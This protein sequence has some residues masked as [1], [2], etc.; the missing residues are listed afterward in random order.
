MVFI[1]GALR[2]VRL[3]RRLLKAGGM[4][5]PISARAR[6]FSTTCS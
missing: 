3:A 4:F 5:A 1:G 6:W 2:A